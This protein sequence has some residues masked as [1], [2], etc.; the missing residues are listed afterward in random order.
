MAARI[1]T[2]S[3][4]NPPMIIAHRVAVAVRAA[5]ATAAASAWC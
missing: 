1:T 4:A 5:S 3:S 2:Q